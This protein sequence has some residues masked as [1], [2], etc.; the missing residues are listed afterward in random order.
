[1]DIAVS[2]LHHHGA[3]KYDKGHAALIAIV[4]ELAPEI[5][6]VLVNDGYPAAYCILHPEEET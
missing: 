6:G 3:G 5:G 1:M 4:S 2:V